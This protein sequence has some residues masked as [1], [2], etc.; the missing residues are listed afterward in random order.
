MISLLKSLSELTNIPK[1]KNLTTTLS[2]IPNIPGRISVV[3][4]PSVCNVDTIFAAI[5]L[6]S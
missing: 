3:F 1:S 2:V 5:P 4:F 6:K